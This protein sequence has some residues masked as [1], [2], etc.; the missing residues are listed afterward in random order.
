MIALSA[1]TGRGRRSH[2]IPASG[3]SITITLNTVNG[4]SP[5]AGLATFSPTVASIGYTGPTNGSSLPE[6]DLY[7]PSGGGTGSRTR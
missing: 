3:Q 1:C 2:Y 6:L 5:P 7:A 4:G